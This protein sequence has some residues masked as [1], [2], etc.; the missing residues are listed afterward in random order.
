MPSATRSSARRTRLA[1][2]AILGLVVPGAASAAPTGQHQPGRT[3]DVALGAARRVPGPRLHQHRENY[4][5]GKRLPSSYDNNLASWT[6][7]DEYRLKKDR[8]RQYF[9][10]QFIWSGFDYIGE[11]TPYSTSGC[12]CGGRAASGSAR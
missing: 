8:D 2:V 10:G 7:S 5:P 4:T 12:R 6:M 1:A 3:V 11:P 9:A